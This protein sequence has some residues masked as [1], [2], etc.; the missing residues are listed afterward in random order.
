MIDQQAFLKINQYHIPLGIANIQRESKLRFE[1]ESVN[2][3]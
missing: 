3:V 1:F 2:R